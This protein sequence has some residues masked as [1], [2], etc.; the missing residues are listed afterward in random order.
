VP[1]DRERLLR[2]LVGFMTAERAARRTMLLSEP[3]L[4]PDRVERERAVDRRRQGGP[5]GGSG[6][7]IAAPAR[8]LDGARPQP[9]RIWIQAQDQL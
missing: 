6:R 7:C 5:L 1:A 3:L 9:A 8:Q 2:L 4:L